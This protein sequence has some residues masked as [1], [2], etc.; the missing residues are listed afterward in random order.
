[1]CCLLLNCLIT[2]LIFS[3][4]DLILAF[5]LV[6]ESCSIPGCS[7]GGCGISCR[8]LGGSGMFIQ[9]KTFKLL[10]SHCMSLIM[11][12]HVQCL[13]SSVYEEL[14]E[15][16]YLVFHAESVSLLLYHSTEAKNDTEII[17]DTCLC[18]LRI[19]GTVYT[20][21]VKNNIPVINAVCESMYYM[22]PRAS[23]WIF[24]NER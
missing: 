8:C 24:A 20:V 13:C 9:A 7:A 18:C 16:Q 1:M 5:S 19:Y 14:Q 23:M 22:C 6:H 17:L 4:C 12:L 15:K 2:I 11:P 10:L 21:S 3:R